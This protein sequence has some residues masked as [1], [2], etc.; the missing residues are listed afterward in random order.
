[1]RRFGL[2]VGADTKAVAWM[3]SFVSVMNWSLTGVF[4]FG[5]TPR[6]CSTPGAGHVDFKTSFK[7]LKEIGYDG[8]CVI[9]AFGLA[10]PALAAATKIWRR[11]FTDELQLAREGLAFMK[12]HA[13]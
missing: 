10:L 8:W 13:S 2:S 6:Q 1:M 3:P 11:M 5:L 4:G 9:E 12:Q 7:T